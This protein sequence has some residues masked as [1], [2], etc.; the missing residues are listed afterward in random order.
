MLFS[1]KENIFKCLVAFQKIFWKIFSGV[2]LYSWKCSR[3]PIFIMFLTFSQLPNKY[4]IKSNKTQIN[5]NPNSQYLTKKNSSN[6]RSTQN[7]RP[8]KQEWVWRDDR[9]EQADQRFGGTIS[10]LTNG[11]TISG[12][13]TIGGKWVW[14]FLG[15]RRSVTNGFDD[16]WVRDLRNGFDSAISLSQIGRASCRERV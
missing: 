11:A 1:G 5:Q 8:T 14:R 10:G 3:K 7:Q 16:F 6:Q 15:S 2:W 12:F 9:R 13:A 4:I